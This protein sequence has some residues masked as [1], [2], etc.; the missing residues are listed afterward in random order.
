MIF[1]Y[2]GKYKSEK[3]LEDKGRVHDNATPFREPDLKV[4]AVIANGGSI[5]ILAVLVA[6]L[7]IIAKPDLRS[8]GIQMGIA[9]FISI[10]LLLPHEFLHAICFKE[11]VYLYRRYPGSK[12]QRN[13]RMSIGPAVAAG[14]CG[15]TDCI[16]T[17]YPF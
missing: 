6:A 13:I 9:A 12:L 3:D 14:L 15:N 16:N 5:L 10:L 11:D 8:L 4:F 17:L 7:W 1:H 2:G